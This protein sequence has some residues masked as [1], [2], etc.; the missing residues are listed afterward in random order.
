MIIGK[1]ADAREQE[2]KAII[3]WL[4]YKH[5]KRTMEVGALKDRLICPIDHPNGI[6]LSCSIIVE[7]RD[8]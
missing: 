8:S 6:G 4:S 7:K 3:Q 1:M 5:V 2:K